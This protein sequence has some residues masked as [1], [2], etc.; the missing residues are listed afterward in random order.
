MEK[1]PMQGDDLTSAIFL[2]RGQRV[3]L[4]EDLALIYVLKQSGSTNLFAGTKAG[5][6]WILCSN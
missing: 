3:M 6:Q 2:V 1:L 5:S 4:D